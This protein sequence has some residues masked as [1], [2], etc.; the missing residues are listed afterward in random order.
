MDV[1]HPDEAGPKVKEAMEWL[2]AALRRGPVRAKEIKKQAR[3]NCI[4]ERTLERA[5]AKL[6]VVSEQPTSIG[7]AWFWSLP[8]SAGR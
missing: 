5:K 1:I 6:G 3:D 7:D 4:S 8:E 2:E